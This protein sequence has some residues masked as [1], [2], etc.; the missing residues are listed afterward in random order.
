M[1]TTAPPAIPASRMAEPW[2]APEHLMLWVHTGRGHVRLADGRQQPVDA[3][4]GIW[5]PAG[6]EHE[7]WTE[8]GSLALPTWVSPQAVPG[9]PADVTRFTV[10]PGWRDWL[11]AHFGRDFTTYEQVSPIDLVDLLDP[12]GPS[13]PRRD[14]PVAAT[15]T[16]TATATAGPYPPMPR[17]A[18]ARVPAKELLRNPALDHTLEQWAALAACSPNT[19][20]RD[21]LSDTGMTFARWRTLCRLAAAREFLEGGYDVGQVAA[22]VGFVSRNGFSRAFREH[23]GMTPRDFAARA[24]ARTDRGVSRRVVADRQDGTLARLLEAA[25]AP[26]HPVP[27]ARNAP[28]TAPY[29]VLTWMYRGSGWARVGATTHPRRQGDT[30]WLPA[31]VERETGLAENSL[32]LPIGVLGPDDAHISEPLTARFPPSWDPYLLYCSVSTNTPLRPEGHDPRHILDVFGEQLAVER[33]RAVP[34]PRD[35]RARDAARDFL[36]RIGTSAESATF[37]VP[38]D[39]LEAFRRETGLTFASWRHAARMSVARDLL[40]GGA[41]PSAVAVRVGYRQVSNFSRAFSRF[42]GVSPREHRERE[43]VTP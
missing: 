18:T 2:D 4:T 23:H 11:I 13:R 7:V 21:F 41:R 35:G 33:A 10:E 34:M 37:E 14:G 17:R 24:A 39:V 27:A 31:G 15:A 43:L 5:L 30:I 36:R 32:S 12:S 22:R 1:I 20:R 42:H 8:P 25:P 38:G 9:A 6:S 29:H 16:A 28:R 3:G 19:L 26:P 40:A